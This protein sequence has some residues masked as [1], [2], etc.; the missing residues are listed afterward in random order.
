MIGVD[1]GGTPT[2]SGCF[3]WIMWPNINGNACAGIN[4]NTLPP[5]ACNWNGS[6]NGNTG[7]ASAGNLPPNGSWTSYEAPLV[8]TAG[9]S[10]VLCLSNY[11][12][13]SGNVNLDFGGTATVSCDPAAGNQTICLGSSA[14]VVINNG[15][16]P[17]PTYEWLVTNGVPNVNAGPNVTVTPVVTTNY[18][19]E[20]EQAA[21]P[22]TPYFIDTISFTITVVTPPTPNAGPDQTV[23]LGSPI[24]LQGVPSSA[25]NSAN[26]QA[27]VPPGLS[28]AA[29]ASFSPNFSNMNPTVTV[30]QPG[31]I[32]SSYVKQVLFAELS[33]I[34][35]Q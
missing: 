24:L 33:V 21:I 35:L 28:P 27:I 16:L 25:S 3:D 5:V 30:N 26:W 14:N 13:L 9:Q 8:V 23:C 17:S 31:P 7:M 1:A 15:G 20:V 12:G 11:S 4:G 34:H 29:T 32:S 19:V 10:F 2:N 6:C 18:L 22:G